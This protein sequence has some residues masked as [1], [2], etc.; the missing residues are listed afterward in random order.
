MELAQKV[1][2]IHVQLDDLSKGQLEMHKQ[3]GELYTAFA[4][5]KLGQVGIIKRV[6]NLED[7]YDR[8]TKFKT[9]MIGIGIGAATVSSFVIDFLKHKFGF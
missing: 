9:K 7:E 4:G 5:N 1:D 6:E 8:L 2:L 3:V